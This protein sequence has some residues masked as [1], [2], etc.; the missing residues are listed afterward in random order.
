MRALPGG[1]SL[2]AEGFRRALILDRG[3]LAGIADLLLAPPA[4]SPEL[5]L[6]AVP[7]RV[8]HLIDLGRLLDRRDR[9][10]AADSVFETALGVASGPAEQAAVRLAHGQV[11]LGR[12]DGR[13]ALAEL[14][15][16]LVLTPTS[17]EVF[18]SLG[19]AYEALEQWADAESAHGSAVL[20]AEESGSSDVNSYRARLAA[21]LTRRGQL[22]RALAL[23]RQVV[24]SAPHDAW[25]HYSL[26]YLH[27]R[28]GEATEAYR[29][30]GRTEELARSDWGVSAE[31]A[32]AYARQGHFQQAVAAYE[33]AVRLAPQPVELRMDL[34]AL[35][36]RIGRREQAIEQYRLVLA[37]E[38]DHEAARRALGSF[39]VTAIEPAG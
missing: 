13:R 5:L 24:A 12:H 4:E 7:P 36:T 32:R 33:T 18:A 8:P 23:R 34:A 10:T 20:L 9:R 21:Y 30:Y 11:L 6:A 39:G 35:L 14:R 26:A 1:S 31:L 22:D 28:R 19:E 2:V 29:E 38:P 25:A 37:R 15:Q 16:A 17:P 27:E 3:S